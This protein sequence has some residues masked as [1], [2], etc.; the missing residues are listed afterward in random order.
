MFGIGD[1]VLGA[2]AVTGFD[3][4]VA[5]PNTGAVTSYRITISPRSPIYVQLPMLYCLAGA[6][7]GPGNPPINYDVVTDANRMI[8]SNPGEDAV[9][10]DFK[11]YPNPGQGN[12]TVAIPSSTSKA[13]VRVEDMSGRIIQEYRNVTTQV[14][15]S[16]MKPG[17]YLVRYIETNGHS[18]SKKLVI[19]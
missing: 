16:P 1:V 5:L 12:I 3:I 10:N 19:Q 18:Q 11:V 14:K 2:G 7:G 6:G 17:L 4:D 15:L 9:N 13:M 8:F